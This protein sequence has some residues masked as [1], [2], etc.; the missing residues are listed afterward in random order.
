MKVLVLGG[1]GFC[2]WP[3]SLHLS[4]IGH[5]VTIVDNLS[6]RE[7]DLELEVESLTPIRPIG[8]R[9]RVWKELTGN[10]I[11]YVHLDLAREYDRLEA[12]LRETQPD[13][14]V[15]FGEQRAAP[16]SMRNATAKRYTVD[17][18]V[19]GTHN[20]LCAIVQSG[21][22]IALVHLGTMGVYGYGWSGSAPI[23]EGYLTVKVPTPDGDI[24][25]EILH[26]ANPGSVYHL[27]KTLD[28]LLFAFYCANDQVRVTDLHQGI[29]WGTQTPQTALDERL[30]NRFDYD[31]D[32]GTVLN[33]FLMQAAIGHPLTVHGTGGQ[34]RAFIHIRDTVR[35]IQIALENPPERGDKPKVFN[36]V[37]ET[38]RVRELAELISKITGAE[39]ANLPNPRREAA[40]NELNV[41]REHFMEL[42]LNPTRL[43]E[44]L[45]EE[46]RDVAVKYR[47]RADTTKIIARSVWRQGM[48][49]SPD[50]VKPQ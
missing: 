29:V 6:R 31:G 22:D 4:D 30:I 2:G 10:E 37:T 32:Y 17:N 45:L 1:D 8:E 26:P 14:I 5:D 20:V 43:S 41:S 11:D 27:T 24:E 23:P 35:C 28:Q 50:L 46:S 12:L 34:T 16:Y 15:H 18:N 48:E 38:H 33:R 49:T 47:D 19:T 25:R 40:E 3:T 7:I 44:G 13:A 42:G 39:I 36:Q 9:I 21:L